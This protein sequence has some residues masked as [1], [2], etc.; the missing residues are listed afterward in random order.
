LCGG[1]ACSRRPSASRDLP[2]PAAVASPAPAAPI[3]Y[4]ARVGRE[5]YRH[6]CQ[7]CHGDTGAGDGFNAFNLD[8]R[9][10]DF[11]DPALLTKTDADIRDAIRRGGAG[12]GLSAL[13]PPWGRTLSERQIDDVMLYLHTLRRPPS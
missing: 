10:R 9:P 11:S 13:M 5:V 2:V 3:P 4:E 8:P 6:Y 7:T 1:A 12:V